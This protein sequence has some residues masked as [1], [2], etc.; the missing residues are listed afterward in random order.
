MINTYEVRGGHISLKD[1][2]DIIIKTDD[3]REVWVLF[4]RGEFTFTLA[5]HRPDESSATYDE[6]VFR[7]AHANEYGWVIPQEPS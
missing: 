6:V 1:G 4:E 5:H 3:G 7:V 2:G